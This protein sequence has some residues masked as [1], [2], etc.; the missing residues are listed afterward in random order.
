MQKN[1]FLGLGS[2]LG[3]REAYL[4]KAI[5][6]L[7]A[8]VEINVL[9]RSQILQTEPVGDLSLPLFLNMAIEVETSLTPRALLAVCLDIEL[10]NGRKRDEKWASRTLDI[11]I[12]FFGELII[13][14]EGLTV[15]HPEVANRR[16][17]LEPLAEIAA[18][19]VNP[20][21]KE[22]VWAMLQRL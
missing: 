6:Q 10:A 21:N 19:Y 1:V 3:G 7:N 9:A 4:E 15:P 8:D 22:P 14:E 2:N 20:V 17:A 12:L 11:D 5:E 18:M 13:D 16:F